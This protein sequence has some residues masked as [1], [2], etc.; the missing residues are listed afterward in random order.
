MRKNHNNN[1][2]QI[3][4]NIFVRI[5]K[6]IISILLWPFRHPFI[7][8]PILALLYFV[9]TLI[10]ARPTEVHIW[11]WNKIKEV[12]APVS[13]KSKA[14]I[15][16]AG[17]NFSI[18]NFSLLDKQDESNKNKVVDA[19]TPQMIRRQIF[20]KASQSEVAI[21]VDVM[22]EQKKQYPQEETTPPTIEPETTQPIETTTPSEPE[23]IAVYEE[24][25]PEPLPTPRTLP[26]KPD[27]IYLSTPQEFSGSA[28]VV[29][30]NE[31]NIGGNSIFLYG[32]YVNPRSRE[33]TLG[34]N[35]LEKLI[36]NE[37]VH[38]VAP[39]YTRQG[40]ATAICSVGNISINHT[41]VDSGYSQNVS[42]PPL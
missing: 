23:K 11:Y 20:E 25:K 35:F 39:A 28:Y 32:I 16:E 40:V 19:N 38:C 12:F 21:R 26:N 7:A 6:R 37:P 29:N 14:F 3:S 13:N 41:M 17:K 10:G 1:R 30:A 5:I 18:P 27:L 24:P 9:P 36:A 2:S 15:A 4:S 42:L 22:A 34:K 31:I 8:L 33:G